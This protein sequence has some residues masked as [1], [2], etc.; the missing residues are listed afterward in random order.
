MKETATGPSGY[1]LAGLFV[2]SDC[3][4]DD[5]ACFATSVLSDAVIMTSAA[6]TVGFVCDLGTYAKR[7][8]ISLHQ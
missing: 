2:V 8:H 5:N 1:K 3:S 6:F 7:L 4:L